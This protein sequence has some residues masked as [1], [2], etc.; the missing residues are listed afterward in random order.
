MSK[1][2]LKKIKRAGPLGESSQMKKWRMSMH[3]KNTAFGRVLASS[4]VAVL[5]TTSLYA[6][7][8]GPCDQKA[9]ENLCCEEPKPGP[10]GFAFPVDM[11]V[12]CPRDFYI[13][14]DGL[15]FQ[16]KQDGMDIGI[17]DG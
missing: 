14:V 11:G 3:F 7:P 1:R 16:A 8:K 10:F 9:P 12:S 2:L 4:V 5:A 17:Y 15:A 6:I 13:H